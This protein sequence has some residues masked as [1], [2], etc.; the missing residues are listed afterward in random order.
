MS[1]DLVRTRFFTAHGVME[2]DAPRPEFLERVAQL[3]ASVA[4]LDD[5]AREDRY[6][7]IIVRTKTYLLGHLVNEN[8]F[9]QAAAVIHELVARQPGFNAETSWYFLGVD[10][11]E[12]MRFN[13]LGKHEKNQFDFHCEN[14]KKMFLPKTKRARA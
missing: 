7:E 4:G 1:E 8:L 3:H 9:G 2:F 14:I 13:A 12:D 6:R 5:D 10:T 11:G